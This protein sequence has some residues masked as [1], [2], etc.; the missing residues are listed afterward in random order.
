MF[1][2]NPDIA[3][4]RIIFCISLLSLFFERYSKKVDSVLPNNITVVN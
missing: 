2:N 3:D 1:A 4:I